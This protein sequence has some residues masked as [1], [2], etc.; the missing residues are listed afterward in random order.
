[1]SGTPNPSLQIRELNGNLIVSTNV[2]EGTLLG[3]GVASA[4]PRNVP[5]PASISVSAASAFLPVD[6]G[7]D[8]DP[9]E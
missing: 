6:D 5:V 7:A 4:G 8:R 2:G 1:M 9:L 3:I